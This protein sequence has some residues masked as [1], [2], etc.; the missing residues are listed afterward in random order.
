VERGPRPHEAARARL[1]QRRGEAEAGLRPRPPADHA[2]EVRTRELVLA[3]HHRVAGEAS[4][5]DALALPGIGACR[6]APHRH[7]AAREEPHRPT[8][9]FIRYT[10]RRS[11]PDSGAHTSPGRPRI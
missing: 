4:L 10:T 8:P 11:A 9:H 5:E 7:R 1:D 6:G 3:G 2:A